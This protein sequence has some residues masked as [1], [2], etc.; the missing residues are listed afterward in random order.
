MIWVLVFSFLSRIPC[1]YNNKNLLVR[2]E[3]WSQYPNYLAIK[4]LNQG[5]Q[6]EIVAIDIAQVRLTIPSFSIH[7]QTCFY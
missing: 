5:G 3:E 1:E 4:L 6:T 7:F 2:V